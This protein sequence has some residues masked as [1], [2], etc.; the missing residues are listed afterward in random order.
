MSDIS[1]PIEIADNPFPG[2][3]PTNQTTGQGTIADQSFPVQKIAS[4]LL[5]AALNTKAK[6]IL[7][8]FS[9]TKLGGLKIGDFKEGITGEI[10]IS[11]EGIVARNIRGDPTLTLDGETGDAT[12]R[13]TIEANDFVIADEKGLISLS[14]FVSDEAIQSS[15]VSTSGTTLSD[16]SG[17]VL[18]IPDFGRAVKM[19]I[20]FT[21]QYYMTADLP[22]QADAVFTI[23]IDGVGID[24][25]Q[26]DTRWDDKLNADR[27][28]EE[29]HAIV[30]ISKGTHQLKVQ[31]KTRQ[32]GGD[33]ATLWS[34]SRTLS[35]VVLGR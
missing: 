8:Q 30:N 7:Q 31:W 9:F 18:S 34:V 27:R 20:F 11:P 15:S 3:A 28:V 10:D 2:Q 25:T 16:L 14:A 26:I 17:A 19:L 12:F 29:T 13:G 23:Q 6:K 4:D 33:T 21:S 22:F 35:Y 32:L 1:T 24:Q 5:S